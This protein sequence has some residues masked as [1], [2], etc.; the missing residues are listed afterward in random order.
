M[1]FLPSLESPQQGQGL[2]LWRFKPPRNH[3][4]LPRRSLNILAALINYTLDIDPK[5]LTHNFMET[6]PF[7]AG[8]AEMAEVIASLIY[9]RYYCF[10]RKWHGKD[11]EQTMVVRNIINDIR[12]LQATDLEKTENLIPNEDE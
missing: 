7:D 4:R 12:D 1:I 3:P 9:E 10:H 5:P 6:N 2:S 8:K 11:A